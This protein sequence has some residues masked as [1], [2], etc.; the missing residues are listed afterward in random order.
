MFEVFVA[1]R[2]SGSQPEIKKEKT[3]SFLFSGKEGPRTSYKNITFGAL[4]GTE[5]AALNPS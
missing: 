5:T 1:T 4:S 2:A 3:F